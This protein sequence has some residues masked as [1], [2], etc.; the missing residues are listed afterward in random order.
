MADDNL[1]YD[2]SLDEIVFENRNKE[3]GAYDLRTAYPKLLT[4]SFFIGTAFFLLLAISPLIYLKIQQM[5]ARD[6]VEVDAK[7]VDILDEQPIIEQPKEEE[8]PPPPPPKEEEK[9]EVIQNVVPE[10]KKAPKIETPPPPITKQLETTTG[11]QNQEGVKTPSYTPPPPP[12]STGKGV[13]AEVK[14]VTNEVYESVDQNAEFPGGTNAFRSKFSNNFD[15]GSLEGEGTLKTEITFVV[16]KDGSLTQVKATGPN[17]DF[18]R[19][20]EATVKGIKTK[21][22]P[23]KVN[24]QPVRSRFRFPVTM[25]FQ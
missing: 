7:L 20:A 18:N 22:T 15:S 8:P 6:K 9:Q 17:S 23:G 21:W 1:K 13:V 14:P 25:N 16:E 19:E 11:L 12:P 2:L 3:Y 24:G 5:N 10:P 4:R